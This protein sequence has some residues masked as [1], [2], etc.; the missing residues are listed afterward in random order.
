ML[1][2]LLSKTIK[3]N[4]NFTGNAKYDAGTNNSI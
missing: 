3:L 2:F 1:L 4:L